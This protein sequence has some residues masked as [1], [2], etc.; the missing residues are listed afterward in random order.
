MKDV[1]KLALEAYPEKLVT[2]GD[3]PELWDENEQ[4]RECWIEGYNKALNIHVVI[5]RFCKC[6]EPEVED[7]F[8]YC[9]NC[10]H[11]IE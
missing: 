5:T 1:N 2:V 8:T 7:G 11:H 4:Y 10:N 9:Y 3:N 6:K